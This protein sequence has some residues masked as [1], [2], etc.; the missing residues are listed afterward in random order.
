METHNMTIVR[1]T[2][3]SLA[4]ILIGANKDIPTGTH[5]DTK[6]EDCYVGRTI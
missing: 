1:G 6:Y 4:T 5:G 3:F 2:H